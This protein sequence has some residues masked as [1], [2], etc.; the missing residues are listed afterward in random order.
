MKE[1]IR[2]VRKIKGLNQTEFGAKIGLSQKAIANIETGAV[3][4]TGRNFDLICKTFGVNPEWLRCGV[5]EVFLETKE[6]V[7]QSVVA[8]FGL[9]A[10][11]TLLMRTFLDLKPE[12]RQG[13]L[14]WAK[15]F[16]TAMAAQMGIDYPDVSEQKA[17]LPHKATAAEKRKL[18][19]SQLDLEEEAEKR[20]TALS[21]S[22]MNTSKKI[23]NS[24]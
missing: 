14:K 24:S 20:A 22:I 2:E 18:I 11:E 16:A 19:N 5:G 17:D 10:E 9:T 8:E 23:P 12:Y 13:V 6:S 7:I 4:L 1:R 21:V 3:S 15:N